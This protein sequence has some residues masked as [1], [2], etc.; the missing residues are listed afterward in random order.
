MS[1]GFLI[2][3]PSGIT[4]YDSSRLA[5]L[6]IDSFYV[7]AGVN[8]SRSYD[9]N[10]LTFTISIVGIGTSLTDWTKNYGHVDVNVSGQSVTYNWIDGWNWP[11]TFLYVPQ[12]GVNITVYVGG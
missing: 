7:A 3:N 10:N 5:L 9:Y 1:Q 6:P 11:G 8:G 2:R 4:I 12:G